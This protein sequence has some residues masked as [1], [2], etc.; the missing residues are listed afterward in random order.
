MKRLAPT[1]LVLAALAALPA[2]DP[3]RSGPVLDLRLSRT[4]DETEP[5]VATFADDRL[6]TAQLE[7]RLA[8]LPARQR[9]QQAEPGGRR[10]LVDSIVHFELLARE[11]ARRELHNDPELVAATKQRMVRLLL[12]QEHA[13]VA[14]EITEA[15][16]EAWYQAHLADFQRPARVRAFHLFLARKDAGGEETLRSRAKAVGALAAALAPRDTR[17]FSELVREHSDDLHSRALGGDLRFRTHEEL[18]RA[19]GAAVADAAFALPR[20]GALSEWI[21]DAGGLHLLRLEGREPALAL[22]LSQPQTRERVLRAVRSAR[23]RE[24]ERALLERLARSASYRVDEAALDRLPL[25]LPPENRHRRPGRVDDSSEPAV[26][27][28]APAR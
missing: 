21:E 27:P 24:A 12:E 15:E 23:E 10:A 7:A 4:A 17:A 16:I 11:A 22:S 8:A 28:A 13:R 9:A 2:C 5:A 18:A 6:T 1:S 19:H 14:S 26:S 3:P 25:D 20:S